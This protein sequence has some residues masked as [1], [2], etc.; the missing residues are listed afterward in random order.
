MSVQRRDQEVGKVLYL[1]ENY[2]LDSDRRELHRGSELV[3]QFDEAWCCIGEA[4]ITVETSNEIWWE[5]E[6]HRTA[7]EIALK[8]AAPDG[9]KAQT[10]YERA[11]AVARKQ[12]AKSLELRAASSMAQLLYDQ[13]KQNA[14]RDL[15]APV[16]NW[17][18]EGIGTR[19]LKQAKALLDMLAK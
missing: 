13:C 18:T 11:L 6:V 19:D 10:Y 7:G 15:L 1:F 8:S 2:R 4:I 3:G 5:A 9:T 12:G 14:A 17:F 16:Y